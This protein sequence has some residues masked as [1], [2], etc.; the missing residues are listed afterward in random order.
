M[1][2]TASIALQWRPDLNIRNLQTAYR[3]KVQHVFQAFYLLQPQRHRRGGS[4]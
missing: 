1:V 3:D 2:S 4:I